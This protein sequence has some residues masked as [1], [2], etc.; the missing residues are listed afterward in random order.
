MT[1]PASDVTR[2]HPCVRT[3]HRIS[4][5]L[6]AVA[7]ALAISSALALPP[8][9][10]AQLIDRQLK[11]ETIDAL[12]RAPCI[13]WFGSSTSR[14]IN[15]AQITAISGK[16]AF[17]ASL[18]AGRPYDSDYFARYISMRFPA[19]PVH[20]IIGLD[21]EQFIRKVD[22][23]IY[24]R[25]PGSHPQP[26]SK[27]TSAGF[28]LRNPYKFET[29]AM[30]RAYILSYY[31]SEYRNFP[32][33]LSPRHKRYLRSMLGYAQATGDTPT[34]VLM[35]V[36]PEFVRTFRPLGRDIRRNALR[37]W[38]RSLKHDGLR[39]R[40]IDLTNVRAFGGTAAGFYDPV[41][42]RPENAA[43]L[44]AY[45]GR[46]GELQCNYTPTVVS[47]LTTV[48]HALRVPPQSLRNGTSAASAQ[49]RAARGTVARQSNEI[50][51]DEHVPQ[52][53]SIV[54]LRRAGSMPYGDRAPIVSS[55]WDAMFI[56]PVILQVSSS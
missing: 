25:R 16:T 27:F 2:Y 53:H 28:R 31:R 10:R 52:P 18:T 11:I 34:V 20:H 54:Q 3:R 21:V 26:S 12:H 6:A 50:R 45:M 7:I 8:H 42:M 38:L 17:N 23:S 48:E 40:F 24:H 41:H 55:R 4:F 39:F 46:I 33:T 14:E 1:Q 15:P 30:R 32:A 51:E 37:T 44:V 43:R 36:H 9:A 47:S 35:P 19:S 29:Y 5:Q 56:W 22:E 49:R 13:T